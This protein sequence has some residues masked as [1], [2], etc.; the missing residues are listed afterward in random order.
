VKNSSLPHG[1]NTSLI[2]KDEYLC[3]KRGGYLANWFSGDD[4]KIEKF[5]HESS[6]KAINNPKLVTFN[7]LKG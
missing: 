4:E 6:K 2:K 5:L 1:L 3:C 7:W